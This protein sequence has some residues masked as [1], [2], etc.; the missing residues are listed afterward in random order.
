MAERKPWENAPPTLHLR[1]WV[2]NP[3]NVRTLQAIHFSWVAT[4]TRLNT[5][6]SQVRDS[7]PLEDQ[8]TPEDTGIICQLPRSCEVFT[9][10]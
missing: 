4:A 5:K 10:P 9:L 2:D 8:S 6:I 3:P 1:L 7:Q